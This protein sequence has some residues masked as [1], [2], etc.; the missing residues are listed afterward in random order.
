[1]VPRIFNEQMECKFIRIWHDV[2][3]NSQGQ[4]RTRDDK[5][6]MATTMMNSACREQGCKRRLS[7]SEDYVLPSSK[8]E[9]QPPIVWPH[10]APMPKVIVLPTAIGC[11]LLPVIAI[12]A[13]FDALI[14]T[15]CCLWSRCCFV[16]FGVKYGRLCVRVVPALLEGMCPFWHV[17]AGSAW[18]VCGPRADRARTAQ[19]AHAC[20]WRHSFCSGFAFFLRQFSV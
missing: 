9:C 19:V 5:L 4:M 18:S 13:K 15:R 20:I 17:C 1:M 7:V 16:L 6:H 12:V 2:L 11:H 3:E 14:F 10:Q 8:K